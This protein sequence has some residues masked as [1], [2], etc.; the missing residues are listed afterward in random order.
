MLVSSLPSKALIPKLETL[1]GMV[2]LARELYIKALSQILVT[3][4]GIKT[5]VI[6]VL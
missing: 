5:L 4:S 2:A 1:S 6:G 3:L